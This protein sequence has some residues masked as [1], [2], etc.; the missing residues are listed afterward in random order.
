MCVRISF[1]GENK[2]KDKRKNIYFG[3]I[4]VTFVLLELYIICT[5]VFSSDIWYDEVFSVQFSRLDLSQMLNMAKR[6]VH[7]PLYYLYLKGC[8]KLLG[9]FNIGEIAACKLASVMPLF[10]LLVFAF[11]WVRKRYGVAVMNA[12]II[13]LVMMPNMAAFY[14]EIRMYSLALMFM[15][16]AY[17]AMIDILR[18]EKVRSIQFFLFFIFA[19][20]AAYTQ[21]FACV[22]IIA[23]YIILIIGL[24]MQKKDRIFLKITAGLIATSIILYLPWLPSFYRQIKDVS[25]SFWI[26]PMTLRSLPGCVKYLLLPDVLNPVAAYSLVGIMII[27]CIIGYVTYFMKDHGIL[28]VIEGCGG[29]AVLSAVIIVGFVFSCLGSPIFTYRYMIPMC[30]I[31]YLNIAIVLLK[32]RKD[33]YV[34]AILFFLLIYG[35]A[36]FEGFSAEETKKVNAWK[37]AEEKLSRIEDGSV[38]ITNFDHVTAI[39]AFYFEDDDIYIYEGEV[40]DVIIDMFGGCEYIDDEGIEKL[41]QTKDNVYFFGSFN[42]RD[43]IVSSWEQKGIYADYLDECLVERYWFNIYR[44]SYEP[45]N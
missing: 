40:S 22:G 43:E 45:Q 12:Y 32:D 10:V 23:V 2:N 35:Y 6:D 42:V 18:S 24:Y 11:A 13:F 38:I 7:P 17:G 41:L 25:G 28:Y 3:H 34:F 26:Q 39:S 9:L 4:I 33:V 36:S 8:V 5:T 14:V 19:L 16:L 29:I 15:T 27:I 21:Y 20:A 31:L 30:G 37:D 44:L 1:M